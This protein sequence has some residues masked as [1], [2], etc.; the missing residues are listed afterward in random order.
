MIAIFFIFS[1]VKTEPFD[2]YGV[3]YIEAIREINIHG[4]AKSRVI[5]VKDAT[6][7]DIEVGKYI[8]TLREFDQGFL[9]VVEQIVQ[10]NGTNGQI[11]TT[12]TSVFE[13]YITVS[14]IQYV[15]NDDANAFET[16]LFLL[17]KPERAIIFAVLFLSATGVLIYLTVKGFLKKKRMSCYNNF[18]ITT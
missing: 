10:I 8:V 2:Y 15:F 9:Y 12:Y 5:V 1:A 7:G 4:E 14:D 6:N 17:E 18:K 11:Q 16:T 13:A 3:K